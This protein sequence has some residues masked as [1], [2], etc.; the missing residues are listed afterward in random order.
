EPSRADWAPS[1]PRAVAQVVTL[2]GLSQPLDGPLL[3]GRSP[4]PPGGMTAGTMRVPSPHHDI[5]RSHVHLEPK[6][7]QI[8]VTDM[9]STNGTIIYMP[10][11]NPLRLENGQSILVPVG[12]T[13]DL[14]DGEQINLSVP[15]G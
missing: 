3:V 8:L 9:N 10:N 1:R 12:T 5:S 15:L 14:G 4:Q 6:D 7:G 11:A 13:L 2:S